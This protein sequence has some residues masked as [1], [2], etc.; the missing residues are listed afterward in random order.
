M[1][2][3]IRNFTIIFLFNFLPDTEIRKFFL[4]AGLLQTRPIYV[5]LT[6]RLCRLWEQTNS[7]IFLC[8]TFALHGASQHNSEL[9]C[10]GLRSRYIVVFLSAAC[11][12]GW[13]V[14]SKLSLKEMKV[15]AGHLACSNEILVRELWPNDNL[16]NFNMGTKYRDVISTSLFRCTFSVFK[17]A[18]R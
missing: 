12:K 6:N 3:K 4:S 13:I 2:W 1:V 7:L 17:V 18:L 16:S 9:Q 11:Q 15:I 10:Q 8:V 5:T 14:E